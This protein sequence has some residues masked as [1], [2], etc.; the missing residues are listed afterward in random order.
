MKEKENKNYKLLEIELFKNVF[1]E[2]YL[3]LNNLFYFF[4]FYFIDK[5][6]PQSIVFY[7]QILLI[8]F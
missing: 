6:G 8:K 5:F 1:Y 2:F 7:I 3:N 4:F